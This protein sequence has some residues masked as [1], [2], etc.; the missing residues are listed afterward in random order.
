M[1]KRTI[2]PKE[3][4]LRRVVVT[5]ANGRTAMRRG[6]GAIELPRGGRIASI[7]VSRGDRGD[8]GDRSDRSDRDAGR[9]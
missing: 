4:Y 7:R 3:A 9:R 1:Q 5:Y 8:R 6:A 2:R